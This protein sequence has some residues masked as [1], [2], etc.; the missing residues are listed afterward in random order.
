MQVSARSSIFA[1]TMKRIGSR[2]LFDAKI[3]QGGPSEALKRDPDEV[4][5]DSWAYEKVSRNL[6]GSYGPA[7]VMLT[8]TGEGGPG[9]AYSEPFVGQGWWNCGCR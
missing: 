7:S 6:K 9:R 8:I 3:A 2:S 5:L 1:L 4:F